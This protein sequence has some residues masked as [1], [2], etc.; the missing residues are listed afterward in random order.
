MRKYIVAIAN[1]DEPGEGL[2]IF[3][4]IICDSK[5]SAAEFI[6]DDYEKEMKNQVGD[7]NQDDY[8]NDMPLNI[9]SKDIVNG[10]TWETP[11]GLAVWTK[12]RVFV[13]N[14]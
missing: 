6:N 12:W 14:I 13:K 4:P 9:T 1:Y 10:A 5:K 3:E 8:E 2:A 11:E 7:Y